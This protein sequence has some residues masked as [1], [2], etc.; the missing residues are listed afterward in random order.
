M[1]QRTTGRGDGAPSLFGEIRS[2]IACSAGRSTAAGCFLGVLLLAATAS[3]QRTYSRP[4]LWERGY[5][6]LPLERYNKAKSDLLN[7]SNVKGTTAQYKAKTSSA[8]QTWPLNKAGYM[9]VHKGATPDFALAYYNELW[10]QPG[11]TTKAGAVYLMTK[12]DS[13]PSYIQWDLSDVLKHGEGVVASRLIAVVMG[14][15]SFESNKGKT[16]G[17]ITLIQQ[18]T[19]GDSSTNFESNKLELKLGSDQ[20]TRNFKSSAYFCNGSG[21]VGSSTSYWKYR[22]WTYVTAQPKYATNLYSQACVK[23]S[24]EKCFLDYVELKI[25]EKD[26]RYPVVGVKITAHKQQTT[27]WQYKYGVQYK[28]L[29]QVNGG[30]R[31]HAIALEPRFAA[32]NSGS[33]VPVLEQDNCPGTGCW[34]AEPMGGRKVGSF[35]YGAR[36]TVGHRGCLLTTAAMALK[37]YNVSGASTMTPKTLNEKLQQ[38]GVDGFYDIAK[39]K[40]DTF[41]G[42]WITACDAELSTL[43]AAAAVTFSWDCACCGSGDAACQTLH[44][45]ASGGSSTYPSFGSLG[46]VRELCCALRSA[47][48]VPGAS[49][50]GS[51]TLEIYPND[52]DPAAQTCDT[53]KVDKFF[54]Y[55][56]KGCSGKTVSTQPR[57]AVFDAAKNPLAGLV[58]VKKKHS[59]DL[60]GCVPMT[61]PGYTSRLW[62][63]TSKLPCKRGLMLASV[64]KLNGGTSSALKGEDVGYYD[65][66]D[67]YKVADTYGLD[68]EPLKFLATGATDKALAQ[69][70]YALE[71]GMA[72]GRVPIIFEGD[73]CAHAV[74]AS[75]LVPKYMTTPQTKGAISVPSGGGFVGTWSVAD[76]SGAAVKDLVDSTQSNAHP[77]QYYGWF[78]M[79]PGWAGSWWLSVRV[80]SPAELVVTGP[81]GKLLGRDPKTQKVIQAISG[82]AYRTM[83]DH[84]VAKGS[85]PQ[86]RYKEA[87]VKDAAGTYQVAVV[88]TGFG[89]F[90]LQL[91]ASGPQKKSADKWHTGH[92]TPGKVYLYQVDLPKG[93]TSA[94][95]FK[96]LTPKD[97]DKDGFAAPADCNDGDAKVAPGAK[98]DCT[99]GKDDDCNGLVDK[100]DPQCN[101]AAKACPDSDKDGYADC[102]VSGCNPAGLACGDCDDARAKVHPKGKEG[103]THLWTCSDDLDNDCDGRTDLDL[104]ACKAAAGS[105]FGKPG[106][107][108]KAGGT[109]DGGVDASGAKDAGGKDADAKDA[110]GKD[111]GAKDAG[112]QDAGT[113]DAAGDMG[114]AKEAGRE[115]GSAD[116]TG[117]G[118]TDSAGAGAD[119]ETGGCGCTMTKDA[120]LASAVGWTLLVLCLLAVRRRRSF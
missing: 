80:F 52:C 69:D 59:L 67:F 84:E 30:I 103:P 58:V 107:G 14:V 5:L 120:S 63:A 37:F 75:G 23:K 64:L 36:G 50:M 106:W 70:A 65:T 46:Q 90:H 81:N 60:S 15:N 42:D 47:P 13:N 34:G 76:S 62:H 11:S 116:S 78:L 95:T 10:A 98:E 33:A 119:D 40:V 118:S 27:I 77:N 9:T 2:I 16:I 35:L 21:C 6:L 114:A 18:K 102:L 68:R 4:T 87:S 32:T 41:T 44:C 29:H 88:G 74:V 73:A 109:K 83:Y 49:G 71:Q 72:R 100:A 38:P 26:V 79:Y 45:P 105:P 91:A 115:A 110:G 20:N 97:G 22:D 108:G 111:A 104:P 85:A 57:P 86:E 51:G 93:A 39:G 7:G 56:F 112:A 66:V 53:D 113:R 28:I 19:P 92:V 8:G 54:G 17:T 82:G 1:N 89:R 43:S 25:P 48:S 24:N 3:A 99:N 55:Q 94:A 61:A 117:A 31:V 12:K 101:A 96:Q